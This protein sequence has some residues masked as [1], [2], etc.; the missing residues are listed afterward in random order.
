[1]SSV[2]S[3]QLSMK[4]SKVLIVG[5]SPDRVNHNAVMRRFVLNGFSALMGSEH[6]N[7]CSLENAVFTIKLTRPKLVV[8]FGSCMPDMSNY[9]PMR[10]I[11]SKLNI[12]IAFWLHDDPY[13]FDFSFRAT[14]VAD[15]IFSNDRWTSFHYEHPKTFFL[16]MAACPWTHYREWN[17]NKNLDILFCG[18]AFNNRVQI[19][20]DL[21]SYIQKQH[22][23]IYGENWPVDICA[24]K[25][26]R[27]SN[28]I[29]THL[30]S[31][32]WV[33]IYMGRDLHLAN[34]RFQ[35]DPSTPGPRLFEAAMAGTVQ[36][37]FV[38]SLEVLDYF[39]LGKEILIF[40]NP[41][42]FELQVADILESPNK[43]KEIAMAAQQRALN[44][45]TY[46]D[47]ARRILK[48][49]EMEHLLT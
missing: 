25:N 37:C 35:L 43:A 19:L 2:V 28:S 11:C 12:G 15:W 17:P 49:C 20:R 36:I 33:S 39:E 23:Q 9:G 32:S 13:E 6:V 48:C 34:K 47:R 38:D 24:A 46:T 44:D 21:N 30:Y 8:C 7:Q 41:K 10:D 29:L 27:V 14:D 42:D 18:V 45:H 5:A 3:T 31:T 16:P 26:I 1:M 40:D 4:E 22:S